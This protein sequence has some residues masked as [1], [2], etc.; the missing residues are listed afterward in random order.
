M[1]RLTKKILVSPHAFEYYELLVILLDS[2]GIIKCVE[3]ENSLAGEVSM[4]T[5]FDVN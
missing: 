5:R 4:D 1:T 2:P 3:N